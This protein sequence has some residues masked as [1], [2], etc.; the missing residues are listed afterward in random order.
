MAVAVL[1]Q[2]RGQA[3]DSSHAVLSSSD[4]SPTCTSAGVATR[5]AS[6]APA[7]PQQLP[8]VAASTPLPAQQTSAAPLNGTLADITRQLAGIAAGES[9]LPHRFCRSCLRCQRQAADAGPF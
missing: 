2:N 1:A 9:P 8:L 7:R 4:F 6:L 5:A 3:A